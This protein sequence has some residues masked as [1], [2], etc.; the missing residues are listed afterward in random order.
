[1]IG[2]KL[3]VGFVCLLLFLNLSGRTPLAPHSAV[4]QI[5][6]YV[7]GGI[8]GGVIY[9]PQVSVLEMVAVMAIWAGLNIAVRLLRMGNRDVGDVAY[10]EWYRGTGETAERVHAYLYDGRHTDST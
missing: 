10:A 9:N 3:A 2:L 8:I 7:M 6:N 5:G 4:D 1:M